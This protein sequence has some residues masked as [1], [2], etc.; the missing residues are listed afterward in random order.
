MRELCSHFDDA[1]IFLNDKKT[2]LIVYYHPT[3][4]NRIKDYP[5][6]EGFNSNESKIQPSYSRKFLKN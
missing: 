4:S 6:P 5:H 3:I 2:T 1:S